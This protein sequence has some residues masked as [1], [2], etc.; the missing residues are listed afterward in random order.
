MCWSTT[1][2]YVDEHLCC[3]SERPLKNLEYLSAI[4]SNNSFAFF[5]LS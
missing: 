2:A 3:F 5:M 1:A 4:S